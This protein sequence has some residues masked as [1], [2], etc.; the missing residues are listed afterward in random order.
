MCWS[1][2]RLWLVAAFF[3]FSLLFAMNPLPLAGN[4]SA[5]PNKELSM[6]NTGDSSQS[7]RPSAVAGAFYTD[8][9]DDLTAHIRGFLAN[10]PA[11][12]LPGDMVA[13]IS[14]HAGYI[15]SGQVAAYGYKLLEGTSF[16]TVVVIAPSHHYPFRGAS[17]YPQG[18]YQIPLGIISIN[19]E[20]AE[21][22][23]E[24]SDLFSYVKQAHLKEHSLEVQLPFLKTLLGD[25]KLLPIVMGAND[26]STCKAIA[27][28]L[29]QAVKGQSVLIVASTDL[30]HFHPYQQAVNLDR[31]VIDYVK[32]Y[33]PEGL[34]NAI[35]SRKCEACGA[36]PLVTTMLLAQ[37]LGATRSELLKYANS[38]DV[39]GDKTQVVG[40][41]SSVLYKDAPPDRSSTSGADLGLSEEDKSILHTIARTAIESHSLGKTPPAIPITSQILKEKRGAFVTLH[42]Q[43]N[44]R[45]CIG[46]IRA[47]KPL[48]QTIREMAIAAAFQDSRFKPVTQGELDDLDIE[49]SVLTPLKK[50][51]DVAEITVGKHGI[52]IIKDY[53]SGL[54]LPQVAVENRWNRE[55]FVKHT[56]TKAGLP[57]DAWKDK[58]TEIYIFSADIF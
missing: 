36:D 29:Y 9:P 51:S 52:Y 17:V 4:E 1:K 19:Q 27:E 13:L 48:Y 43:A 31:I 58:S 7:V 34:S 28:S 25:F 47:Q 22:L 18:A 49:I 12:T 32:S 8:D 20:L 16:D 2:L 3:S 21:Q 5:N 11:K 40:Y 15:Y 57:E 24:A 10:V 50:I 44:L 23:I 55:S 42:N 30:S 45:G 53:H 35:A 54:L 39:S 38:G 14:P 41:M 37:K 26:F 46:Y 33:D 56:C 6:K